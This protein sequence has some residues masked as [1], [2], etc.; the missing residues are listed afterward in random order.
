MSNGK[1][2]AKLKNIHYIKGIVK[3]FENKISYKKL[4]G[5]TSHN[6]GLS[7]IT[8]DVYIKEL[9]S[10]GVFFTQKE[11]DVVYIHKLEAD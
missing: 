7:R 6:L 4:W 9:I 11:G 8:F 5:I 2:K 10:D 3:G 1:P